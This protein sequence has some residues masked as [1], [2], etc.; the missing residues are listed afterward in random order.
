MNIA[1]LTDYK[2]KDFQGGATITGK[3]M[4]TEGSKRG[5]HINIYSPTDFEG[6]EPSEVLKGSDLVILNNI[7]AF[8]LEIIEWVIKKKN[9][10]KYE[11]DYCFCQFRDGKCGKEHEKCVPAK[12]FR[13]MFSNSKLNIFFSPLQLNIFKNNFGSELF[14]DAIYIPA[15]MERDTF[16]PDKNLQR[17]AYL[18]AG[19]IMTH[20]GV[21]Q[22][23][24]F[25][26][27]LK[28][29]VF[30]FAGKPV[31]KEFLE[32]IKE[33]HTYLGEFPH[34]DMP[35]LYRKYKHFVINPR[36][37]ETFCLTILEAMASGCSIVKFEH[38]FETGLESYGKNPVEMMEECMNAPVKFWEAIEG[39]YNGKS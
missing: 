29:K 19:A 25:A 9:Y 1:W 37:H 11:H 17:D 13:D 18:Y 32:K 14:R 27:S 5:H 20:K 6:K 8:K 36:M 23:I 16:Y 2:I 24:D 10:I 22:I 7:N 33:K 28:D 15:P 12:I 34:E 35:K 4:V 26:D 39:V 30:H 31:N 21:S 38:S 3:I